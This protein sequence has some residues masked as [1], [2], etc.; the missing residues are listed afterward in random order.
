MILTLQKIAIS[1]F[2]GIK[3]LKLDFNGKSAAISGKNGVGKSS[4]VDAFTWALFGTN[5]NGDSPG[6]DS[7]REKPLDENGNIIH[8]LTTS[9][10]LDF[11]LDEKPFSVKRVL[12]ENWI[13]RRGSAEQT[14]QGNATKYYINDVE[15]KKNEFEERIAAIIKPEIFRLIGTLGAFNALDWKKRRQYLLSMAGNEVD[16]QLLQKFEYKPIAAEIEKRNISVDDLKKVLYDQKKAIGNELKTLP[17]RIDEARMSLPTFKDH[18]IEDATYMIEEGKR[19]IEKIERMIIDTK[20]SGG[21]NV[22]V[23]ALSLET[24]LNSVKRKIQEDHDAGKRKASAD[25]ESARL[26]AKTIESIIFTLK[27]DANKLKVLLESETKRRNDLRA[28]YLRVKGEKAEI[29]DTCPTC[30]QT[31]PPDK[32]NDAIS[33][34]EQNRKKRLMDIQTEGKS[35]ADKIAELESKSKEKSFELEQTESELKDVKDGISALM[36]TIDHYPAEPDYSADFRIAEIESK[37]KGLQ[38]GESSDVEQKVHDLIERKREILALIDR[39]NAVLTKYSVAEETQARIKTYESELQSNGTKLSETELLLGA[40]EQFAQDRCSALED[41]IN[42][43]FKTVKWKLFNEQIN[44]GIAECCEAMVECDGN[45]VPYRSANTARQI[46]CDIEIADVLMAQH[47]VKITLFVD[48]KERITAL[49]QVDTQVIT[50]A[51]SADDEL[52]VE[53]L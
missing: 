39:N 19:D 26:K 14:F 15:L 21:S 29:N 7:F 24:E 20:A 6:S 31:L 34:W 40:I 45:L 2:K 32:V 30:G 3:T 22:N 1:S 28:E 42:G 41:N 47:G 46:S 9:V 18:E 37:I 49:P 51:V 44:G 43:H 13:K 53:L 52:K 17:V 16:A 11:L 48:N 38:T 4:I 27:D 50:L 35:C 33:T 25:L 12:S 10:Q 8:H 5:S 23:M 36:E